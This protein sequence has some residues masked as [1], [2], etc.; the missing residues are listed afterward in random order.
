MGSITALRRPHVGLSSAF[1][2]LCSALLAFLWGEGRKGKRTS[3]DSARK[4]RNGHGQFQRAFRFFP[5]FP[6]FLGF[7]GKGPLGREE[8]QSRRMGGANEKT[9]D[10][11]AFQRAGGECEN[12]ASGKET[13]NTGWLTGSTRLLL[14]EPWI[15][16]HTPHFHQVMKR[17]L[18][19]RDL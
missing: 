6:V 5:L 4:N 10:A 13:P 8:S 12:L 1:A 15:K 18:S 14:I 2:R 11:A 17:I 7:P 16:P 19:R 9:G 3:N